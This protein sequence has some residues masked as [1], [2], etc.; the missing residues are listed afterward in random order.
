MDDIMSGNE[1]C[2]ICRYYM[3]YDYDDDDDS[4]SDDNYIRR[5]RINNYNRR[6]RGRG[7]K[8]Q[9][10]NGDDLGNVAVDCTVDVF[11]E[12]RDCHTVTQTVDEVEHAPDDY[13][14]G[15]DHDHN[16]GGDED[17]HGHHH[18][19]RDHHGDDRGHHR[20]RHHGHSGD[21]RRSLLLLSEGTQPAVQ[22]SVSVFGEKRNC[23]TASHTVGE[24]ERASDYVSKDSGS[25]SDDDNDDDDRRRSLLLLS[26]RT[27]PAVQCSVSVF[28]EKRNCHTATHT[29]GEVERASDYLS[30]GCPSGC[31]D[32]D[33]Q[34]GVH[35]CDKCRGGSGS[36]DDDNDDDDD[37]RR[38]L[39]SHRR[40][41]G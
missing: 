16:H 11:G 36:D 35:G 40:H 13:Y 41:L 26:E 28:G 37:R 3:D 39:L 4:D 2:L 23:H 15:H 27:Q 12:T 6:G 9:Q 30:K 18:R 29:V 24:V 7:R 33:I 20:H 17:G 5:G 14:V 34:L 1:E 10:E 22:C 25:G 21:R 31:R 19:H 8:L 32:V 38:S